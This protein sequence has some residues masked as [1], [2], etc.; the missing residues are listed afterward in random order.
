MIITDYKHILNKTDYLE[1]IYQIRC[2]NKIYEII[3]TTLSPVPENPFKYQ[4]IYKNI[5]PEAI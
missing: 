3:A 2:Y 1:N 5:H 4:K